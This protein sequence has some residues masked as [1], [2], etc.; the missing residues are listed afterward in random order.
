MYRDLGFIRVWGTQADGP[1]E[2]AARA[3][4]RTPT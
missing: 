2:P 3:A 1:A 4:R